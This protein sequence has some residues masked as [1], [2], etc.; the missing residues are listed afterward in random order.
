L[1]KI[2]LCFGEQNKTNET[3]PFQ[4]ATPSIY[5]ISSYLLRI[6]VIAPWKKDVNYP[7]FIH[8]FQS[9]RPFQER[10]L[11]MNDILHSKEHNSGKLECTRTRSSGS[12]KCYIFSVGV[13]CIHHSIANLTWAC[14]WFASKKLFYFLLQIFFAPELLC[15][16]F[17]IFSFDLEETSKRQAR[18]GRICK[19]IQYCNL[20]T[21]RVFWYDI[22]RRKHPS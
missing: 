2:L 9:L 15:Y 5:T 17:H 4:L 14:T 21:H 11:S 8:L 12:S 19:Y 10:C 7:Y 6:I 18:R 1:K 16:V 20:D 13:Q 3:D 22:H